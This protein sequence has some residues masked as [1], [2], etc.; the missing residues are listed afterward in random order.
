M[1]RREESP[2]DPAAQVLLGLGHLRGAF[3]ESV[4][5]HAARVEG[6][7]SSI[8]QAVRTAARDARGPGGPRRRVRRDL[9][10]MGALLDE[11]RLKPAKGRRKDLRRVEDLVAEL[12]DRTSGW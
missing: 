1:K 2:A 9:E 7:I 3:R 4:E 5:A 6:E 10:A 8:A 12:L 11:L